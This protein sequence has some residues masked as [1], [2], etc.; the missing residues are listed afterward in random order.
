MVSPGQLKELQNRHNC[1][2]WK[3]YNKDGKSLIDTNL[4][5]CS[6]EQSIE[7]LQITLG[8]ILDDYVKVK[9]YQKKPFKTEEN[10]KVEHP[11]TYTVRTGRNN[12]P[13]NN[14]FVGG[15]SWSDFTNLHKELLT[16][17]IENVRIKME[18]EYEKKPDF[19]E[20]HGPT[21]LAL[22]NNFLNNSNKEKTNKAISQ[23]D[24]QNDDIKNVILNLDPEEGER[25]YQAFKNAIQN[26]D[27]YNTLKNYIK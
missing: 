4:P 15:P 16:L 17:Q 7:D 6:L 20:Q 10:D 18:Q 27:I 1:K 3:V 19:F 2:Y 21:L 22:A 13:G 23:P 12:L 11:L 9:L 14:N 5:D 8:N 24:Q 25:T 26:P